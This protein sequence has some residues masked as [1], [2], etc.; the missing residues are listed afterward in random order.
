MLKQ[1]LNVIRLVGL[2]RAIRLKKRHAQGLVP[3]RGHVATRCFWTLLQTGLWDEV[4]AKG[5]ID[6]EDFAR[7]HNL[8]AQ[9]LHAVCKYLDGIGWVG[10]QGSLLEPAGIVGT[11]LQEPRGLYELGYAY[12][13]VMNA[14]DGLLS[15]KAVFGKDVQRRTDWVGIGSGRLCQQLPYPVLG[16]LVAR[17]GGKRVIDLG[18]GDGAF[19][20]W[21]LR[22]IPG[23]RV[24]G[25][26]L[27]APTADLAR[28]RIAEE[29]LAGRA[30]VLRGDMFDL[31]GG[32]RSPG[33]LPDLSQVDTITVCDTFHEYLWEGED[34]IVDFLKGLKSRRPG[35]TIVM[36]DF[37]VQDEDW[38]RKHPIASLEHHLWHDL[39]R[40]RLISETQWR[41]VFDRAGMQVVDSR[42]FDL[43]GHGYFVIR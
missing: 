1:I 41:R 38:L 20:I 14:L 11:L 26:D 35:I 7:R 4:A 25:L 16:D 12:E 36:G 23:L 39:T 43:I 13:P 17:Y 10:L 32:E 2:G 42:V 30:T 15:G 19:M 29:N 5:R 27:D 28:R 24:T 6:I 33:G 18:C 9:T 37:C 22:H 40:Q 8:N 21:M 34:P 31:L 3:L